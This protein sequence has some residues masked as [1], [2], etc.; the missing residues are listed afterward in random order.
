MYPDDIVGVH[1]LSLLLLSRVA[2]DRV[3]DNYTQ[4]KKGKTASQ[5]RQVL[6]GTVHNLN[7]EVIN[8]SPC[9]LH[10]DTDIHSHADET[11]MELYA[12]NHNPVPCQKSPLDLDDERTSQRSSCQP[13]SFIDTMNSSHDEVMTILLSYQSN[14]VM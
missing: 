7:R 9:E 13:C 4:H 14:I 1:T 10:M 11:V 5:V 8:P 6:V 3:T 12:N 2:H